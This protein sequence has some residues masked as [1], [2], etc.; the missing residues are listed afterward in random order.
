MVSR[1]P[2][3]LYFSVLAA[4]ILGWHSFADGA[5]KPK[6]KTHF[7]FTFPYQL[8]KPSLLDDL[9]EKEKPS[10]PRFTFLE[11]EFSKLES[12]V[13]QTLKE[14]YAQIE[15]ESRIE[16][17]Y[18]HY[19]D[20]EGI[21]INFTKTIYRPIY[22]N[23]IEQALTGANI[24]YGVEIPYSLFISLVQGESN[25][26][27]QVISKMG[28]VGLMQFMP[29]TTKAFGC[30]PKSPK[31]LLCGAQFLAKFYSK[32]EKEVPGFT[33]LPEEEK[34]NWVLLGYNWGP[35][36]IPNLIRTTGA[37]TVWDLTRK[38]LGTE[39]YQFVPK[40]RGIERAYLKHYQNPPT[41]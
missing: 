24:K 37:K 13:N 39:A 20:R 40:I 27:T 11:E 21:R 31:Q 5:P 18:L 34:W 29:D 26:S 36:G 22:A 17:S 12:Q 4:S 14:G 16:K 25:W 6:T 8:H 33:G 7:S 15:K 38:H 41:S 19:S 23:L 2:L 28:A 35:N 1:K 9:F 10:F 3:P 32:Y 30:N